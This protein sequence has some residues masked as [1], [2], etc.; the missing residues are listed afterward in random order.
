[1]VEITEAKDKKA[2]V[3]ECEYS[4]DLNPSKSINPSFLAINVMAESQVEQH[5]MYTA[6]KC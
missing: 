3:I 5:G 4:P 2:K 6:V 1:V